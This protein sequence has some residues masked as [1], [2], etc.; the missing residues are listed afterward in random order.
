M[1]PLYH[2]TPSFPHNPQRQIARRKKAPRSKMPETQLKSVNTIFILLLFL[3]TLFAICHGGSVLGFGSQTNGELD[4]LAMKAEE[5]QMD[6]ESNRR[7]LE[8]VQKRYISYDTLKRD[9]VPCTRP[10][11]SYYNCKAAGGAN[12]YHRGCEAI[13]GCARSVGDING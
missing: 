8:M 9:L 3:H 11:A 2:N 4:I 6:S 13:T 5:L 10:G 1:P 7:V 12:P